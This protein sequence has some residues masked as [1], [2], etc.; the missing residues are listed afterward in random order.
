MSVSALLLCINANVVELCVKNSLKLAHA[1]QLGRV[2][3]KNSISRM[4]RAGINKSAK[5]TENTE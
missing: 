2:N 1:A 3:W 5:S 4:S